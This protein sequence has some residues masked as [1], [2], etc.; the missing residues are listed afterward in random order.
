MVK[1]KPGKLSILFIKI[2]A[3]CILLDSALSSSWAQ[4][5]VSEG[6]KPGRLDR[7]EQPS[8]SD[9]VVTAKRWGDTDIPSEKEYQEDEILS[10]GSSSIGEL[11]AKFQKQIDP[12]GKQPLLLINGRPVVFDN[13]ILSFPPEALS[14]LSVLQQKAEGEYGASSGQKVVNLVLKRSFSSTEASQDASF[15]LAGG[16]IGG[17]INL[18]HFSIVDHS[19]W[20][21][22]LRAGGQTAMMKSSR[23]YHSSSKTD[24]R[25][26]DLSIFDYDPDD[27]Q[28]LQPSSSN[29]ALGLGIVQPVGALSA[30]LDLDFSR[31]QSQTSTG[32]AFAY[33]NDA[34][35]T[36][37][38]NSGSKTLVRVPILGRSKRLSA[39]MENY[40]ASISIEGLL[41]GFRA[42]LS[43]S[44]S[45]SQ[46]VIIM[47]SSIKD[48]QLKSLLRQ[49]VTE[50]NP[51][52]SVTDEN[53]KKDTISSKSSNYTSRFTMQRNFLKLPSG[54]LSWG[55]SATT[56]ISN[57]LTDQSYLADRVPGTFGRI[58]AILWSGQ[59]SL[60]IPI[61][62]RA[63][64]FGALGDLTA[65]ITVGR[66]KA[67]ISGSQKT[68]GIGFSWQPMRAFQVAGSITVSGGAASST[69][70]TQ[71]ISVRIKSVYDY[72]KLRWIDIDWITGGIQVAERKQRDQTNLN[73]SL[74]V[75]PFNGDDF[76]ISTTYS[77]N[78][79]N[80]GLYTFSEISPAIEIN[81]PE[82]I[83]RD[84]LGNLQK[85]DA[86]PINMIRSI[87]SSILSTLSYNFD[88][89][90]RHPLGTIQNGMSIS[91]P[92]RIDMALTHR[93]EIKDEL[94]FQN[95]SRIDRFKEDGNVSRHLIDVQVGVRKAAFG[96]S[97]AGT[98]RS[99]SRIVAAPYST[100]I[101]QPLVINISA[102]TN[103]SEISDKLQTTSLL[104]GINVT[105]GISN[106]LYSYR[107][108]RS[109][110]PDYLTP[111]SRSEI[112]PIGRTA[113]IT[114]R[115][116]F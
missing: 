21:T 113:Q 77:K 73:A 6:S 79:E 85:V 1:G 32:V 29:L 63:S 81:Y 59:L 69:D 98:W 19:R 57:S 111:Q 28:T 107:R 12:T 115:K 58:Q 75:R 27:Y 17:G 66:S 2:L 7:S 55:F 50:Y 25:I 76:S 114:L 38:E 65:N 36:E 51:Y 80:G 13:S 70:V 74:T 106:L 15:P 56:A 64:A 42:A 45:R 3:I 90:R 97:I 52:S 87:R 100:Y 112:D 4:V 47:E 68:T 14:R 78:V 23:K 26:D 34:P 43:L 95:Y 37:F 49:S 48:E 30:S 35:S 39:K 116:R 18:A 109:N 9:I 61:S 22:R 105:V 62:R 99:T 54:N 11:L 67:T 31:S 82:R 24:R 44:A 8:P 86:R 41:S 84:G 33:V 108:I 53:W 5:A 88:L 102:F 83:Y 72:R 89:S 91:S 92:L 96:A 104:S 101:E 60:G 110:N 46:N 71:P 94:L 20:T 16:Q 103:T 93:F 10:S 40:A